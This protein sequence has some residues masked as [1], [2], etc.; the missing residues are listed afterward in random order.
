MT[1]FLMGAVLLFG[2]LVI[3]VMALALAV[4]TIQ[5]VLYD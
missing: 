2:T 5:I 4:L 3:M 1:E